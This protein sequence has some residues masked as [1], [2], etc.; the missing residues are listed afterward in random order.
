MLYNV[1]STITNFFIFDLQITTTASN[2]YSGQQQQQ[3]SQPTQQQQSQQQAS[4]P[5]QQQSQISG[6]GSTGAAGVSGSS[7]TGAGTA[8]STSSTSFSVYSSNSHSV[9]TAT[10]PLHNSVYHNSSYHP[11]VT[12]SFPSYLSYPGS[13]MQPYQVSEA[14]SPI[15][16][17]QIVT[18]T[19]MCGYLFRRPLP[20]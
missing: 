19:N 18:I 3:A 2:V 4:Q 15:R 14:Y 6:S 7:A 17:L 20:D 9:A 12:G 11:S 13:L 16:V 5:P 10:P 8:Y 1:I